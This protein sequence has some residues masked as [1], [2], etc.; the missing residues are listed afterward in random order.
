VDLPGFDPTALLAKLQAAGTAQKDP[1]TGNSKSWVGTL[2]LACIALAGVAVWA[3]I[4]WRRNQELAK[5]RHEKF[6]VEVKAAQDIV[7]TKIAAN[8]AAI[9]ESQKVVAASEEKVRIIQADI[10]AEE[11]RY[12]ADLR[13]ID[14]I[15]SWRDID[16]SA[17]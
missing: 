12:A 15:R 3:W 2:I 6:V 17:R 16:P 13:A 8:S 5:L 1:K 9:A 7:D 11:S 10:R 14:S 4:S